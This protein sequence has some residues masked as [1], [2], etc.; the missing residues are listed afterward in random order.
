MLSQGISAETCQPIMFRLRFF[1][2]I[3][4][5]GISSRNMLGVL[6]LAAL[7]APLARGSLRM[8]LIGTKGQNSLHFVWTDKSAT[9]EIP[10]QT[11]Q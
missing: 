2:R 7:V 10:K 9:S 5:S 8:T 6:R 1:V 11:I 4:L 3:P